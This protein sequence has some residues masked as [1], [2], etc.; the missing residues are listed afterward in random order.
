MTDR[1]DETLPGWLR[2][3]VTYQVYIRSFADSDGDGIGDIGGIRERLPYL[4]DLG[5]DA[6][7]ITPWYRSPMADGGYDVADYR[8]IDPTFGTL[9]GAVD[10]VHA[11]HDHG[12][13]VLLDIVPNH[14]SADHAWFRE[15][16]AAGPGS[17][18]RDRYIF[19]AGSGPD[20]SAPPNNWQSVFGGAAWTRVADSDGRP[21][22][23]YL[24][25][26][27]PAQPDL[28]WTN[29]A[30]RA[31]FESILDFWFERGVDG[32]RIDVAMGLV[33]DPALPDAPAGSLGPLSG[34]LPIGHPFFD[35]DGVHAIWR[36]WRRRADRHQPA[37]VFVGEVA[38]I[39]PWRLALYVR[40][41]ELHGVFN[42][43][44]LRSPW[45]ATALR[46]VIDDHRAALGAVGASPTW[47]LSNH[48]EARHLSRYGRPFSGVRHPLTAGPSPTD[49][50]LGTRRARAAALL[51][52]ALPGSACLYQ[53]EELGLWEV[54]DLPDELLQ[55][56]TWKRSGH[57]VR[58]RD[59]C[60]VPVPWSGDGPP[61]GF[62]PPGSVPWLPQPEAWR[63]FSV[64]AESRDA[65]SMLAL[66]R[67]ALGLRREHAGFAGDD[68]RWLPAPE[69]SLVFERANGLRCAVNLSGSPL[70]LPVG[71][72]TLL[73]STPIVADRLPVDAAAWFVVDG[74][75]VPE[76]PS[77]PTAG[78]GP[79]DRP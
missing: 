49:V 78:R 45:E 35:G 11:A 36:S 37:R 73:A 8:E 48:D 44:F 22:E 39:E 33:K 68:L 6:L 7:W 13:R 55:D 56:P 76:A 28:D 54:E 79:A 3:A 27:D 38:L 31:E 25:L 61:F 1:V 77:G 70:E 18:A 14:T 64:D 23:W 43:D 34:R 15:A 50:A 9:A 66:Y 75:A 41:D 2:R 63:G 59:G 71:R 74:D 42:F 69:G 53:G 57:R 12:L 52:L 58:G 51:M 5:V 21:G 67:A 17:A 10:L 32:L 46:T 47:V 29:P 40:P 65:G 62:G 72:T 24:H 20:G 26:F 60:R 16:L 19:R 30:V 4:R